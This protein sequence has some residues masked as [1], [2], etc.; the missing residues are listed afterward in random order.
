MIHSYDRNHAAKLVPLLEAIFAE[1][2]DRRQSI[3]QL[4]RD[5]QRAKREGESRAV[6]SDITARLANHRRELR[7][8][9]KEFE[10][11]GCVV[12][13]HNPNRVIIPGVSGN[14]DEGFH[15]QAGTSEVLE[16]SATDSSVF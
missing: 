3:R 15:W 6:I 12:D 14:Y 5:L 11:L 10:H 8:T 13:E 4:E 16:N 1:V 7:M 2:A 9:S